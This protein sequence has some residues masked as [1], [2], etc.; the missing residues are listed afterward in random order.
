MSSSTLGNICHGLNLLNQVVFMG[1]VIGHHQGWF[2]IL[3][4][5]YAHDGFCISNQDQSIY[6]QSHALCFYSDTVFCIFLTILVKLT[7][8]SV[9]ESA[10]KPL[11]TMI[12]GHFIHGATHMWLAN[13]PLTKITHYERTLDAPQDAMKAIAALSL[14]WFFLIK[15]IM[16]TPN[17]KLLHLVALTIP[18]VAVHFLFISRLIAFSYVTIILALVIVYDE[19][20]TPIKD[21]YYLARVLILSTPVN[22]IAWVEATA[23]HSFLIKYGGHFCYDNAI[24]ISYLAYFTYVASMEGTK[25]QS[26]KQE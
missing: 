24:P 20:S 12:P 18:T 6:Y 1:T 4:P 5:P 2:D 10:I 26:I 19:L 13:T 17:V 16:H 7:E 14:F 9:S 23:C 21:K 22:V 15:S 8:N 11:K 25:K 3:S